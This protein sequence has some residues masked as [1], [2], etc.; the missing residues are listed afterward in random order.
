[1]F[2]FAVSAACDAVVRLRKTRK[3]TLATGV[4]PY[5][6]YGSDALVRPILDSIRARG[7]GIC[8]GDIFSDEWQQGT[9][10]FSNLPRHLGQTDTISWY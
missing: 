5:G 2:L 1:M 9:G 4:D 10:G 6:D 8:W 7:N 3:M